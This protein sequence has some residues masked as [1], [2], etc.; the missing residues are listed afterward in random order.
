MSIPFNVVH[1]DMFAFVTHNRDTPSKVGK[2]M[3]VEGVNVSGLKFTNL[4]YQTVLIDD[5]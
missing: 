3:F 5:G 1:T 4:A 2:P